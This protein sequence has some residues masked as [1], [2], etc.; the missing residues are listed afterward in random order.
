MDK[1][2]NI[3]PAAKDS[4][5]Y[6]ESPMSL[7]IASPVKA[8]TVSGTVKISGTAKSDTPVTAVQVR[9]DGGVWKDA[10]GTGNWTIDW[11]TKDYP[12]GIHTVEV[13]AKDSLG[14]TV[15]NPTE[16]YVKNAASKPVGLS[17]GDVVK[18]LDAG[19]RGDLGR[20]LHHVLCA[21]TEDPKAPGNGPDGARTEPRVRGPRASEGAAPAGG[22]RGD[23]APG[24]EKGPTE[25]DPRRRF[26]PRRSLRKSL[27]KLDE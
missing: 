11:N 16:V 25:K 24:P 22:P 13:Q 8:K 6:G 23:R 5:A 21:F 9:I 2:G 12:D 3:A 14:Y 27:K 19:H 26:P 15:S 4:I 18:L 10:S 1:A 17:T 20:G 7:V